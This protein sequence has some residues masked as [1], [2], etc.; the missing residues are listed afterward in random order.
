VTETHR[1]VERSAQ[2]DDELLK[3]PG[4]SGHPHRFGGTEY[5]LGRREIGHVHGNSLVDVPLPRRI[6]D[7]LV[8]SGVARPH[9]VLPDSG[10][11]SVVLRSPEDVDTAVSILRRSYDIAWRQREQ[12]GGPES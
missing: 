8:T 5:R 3:W 10:W 6:R 11:V 1:A 9:H 4:V 7:E 2:I 12:R